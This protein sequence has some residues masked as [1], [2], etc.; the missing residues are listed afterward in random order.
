MARKQSGQIG[1]QSGRARNG[2]PHC[3]QTWRTASFVKAWHLT[4]YAS[5]SSFGLWLIV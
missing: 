5:R 3:R 1:G 4:Q 2:V